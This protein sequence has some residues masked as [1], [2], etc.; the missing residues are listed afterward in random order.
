MIY[1]LAI[2]GGAFAAYIGFAILCVSSFATDNQWG[3]Y[4]PGGVALLGGLYS[5]GWGIYKLVTV[6]GWT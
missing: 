6:V 4:I 5:V 2:L 3:L 1:V